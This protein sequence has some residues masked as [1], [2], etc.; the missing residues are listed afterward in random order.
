MKQ[1]GFDGFG[2]QIKLIVT[3]EEGVIPSD[4]QST[5]CPAFPLLPFLAGIEQYCFSQQFFGRTDRQTHFLPCI[6]VN[7]PNIFVEGNMSSPYSFI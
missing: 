6:L 2:L 4:N 5:Y 1:Q 3:D 7:L